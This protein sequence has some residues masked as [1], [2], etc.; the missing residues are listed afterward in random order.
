MQSDILNNSHSVLEQPVINGHE[1]LLFEANIAWNAIKGWSL[2][3]YLNQK[4]LLVY[5]DR[6]INLSF[7]KSIDQ[8]E[9]GNQLFHKI[10][11]HHPISKLLRLMDQNQLEKIREI[12]RNHIWK[13]IKGDNILGVSFLFNFEDH[14]VSNMSRVINFEKILKELFQNQYGFPID[15]CCLY[16]SSIDV[17]DFAELVDLHNGY[18]IFDKFQHARVKHHSSLSQSMIWDN[19]ETYELKDSL[20]FIAKRALSKNNAPFYFFRGNEI[21]GIA[22]NL[23]SFYEQL[24]EVPLD[25]FCFHCYRMSQ[26]SLAGE[27]TSPSPRSDI[28]LWIEYSLGDMKLAH[29]IFDTVS[30]SMGDG[31][32]TLES[33]SKFTKSTIKSTILELIKSRIDFLSFGDFI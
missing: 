5:D 28:A 9:S 21:I 30:H 26:S 3:Q 32:K 17:L 33:A 19:N 8:K 22:H 24:A 16:P 29:Q 14:I 2:D 18:Q 12:L 15:C 11:S 25:V 20:P 27:R 13:A 10:L 31:L 1:M 4:E 6:T 7:I 23:E